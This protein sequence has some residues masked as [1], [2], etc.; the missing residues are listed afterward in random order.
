MFNLLVWFNIKS[1]QSYVTIT[2]DKVNKDYTKTSKKLLKC[3]SAF[4]IKLGLLPFLCQ[5]VNHTFFFIWL[6]LKWRPR[7]KCT[8]ILILG[9]SEFHSDCLGQGT[10]L[11]LIVTTKQSQQ[12]TG[13]Q[14]CSSVF[15]HTPRRSSSEVI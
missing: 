12:K 14:T 5:W 4:W 13:I 11:C 7:V 8:D 10:D 9:E 6:F 1:W 15:K 3:S 2:I